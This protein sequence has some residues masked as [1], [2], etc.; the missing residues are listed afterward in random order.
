MLKVIE[1]FSRRTSN[2]EIISKIREAGRILSEADFFHYVMGL[3]WNHRVPLTPRDVGDIKR[4][5]GL[6]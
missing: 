4:A 1:I 3:A 6:L 5:L 2:S